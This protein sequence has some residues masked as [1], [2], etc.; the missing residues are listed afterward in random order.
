MSQ[1]RTPAVWFPTVHTGTGT[2]VFTERLAAGLEQHGVRTQIEWL[3]LRAEYA[4][5]TVRVPTPPDWATVAH[6]NTWLRPHFLPRRLPIVATV[7]HCMHTPSLRGRKGIARAAYHRGW[8]APGERRVLRRARC[9]VA[10]SRYVAE[11][12]TQ[13]LCNVDMAVIHN[14]V[15]TRHFCPSHHVRQPGGPFRLLY[16]GGWKTLKGVDLLAPIMR[17]LGPQF[18]LRY[19]GVGMAFRERATMPANTRDLGRL[20]GAAVVAEMQQ[21]DALLFPS[22]SEGFGQVVAEAMACGLPVIAMRGSS[23]PELVD[24]GVTGLLCPRDDV[25]AFVQAARHLAGDVVLRTAMSHAARQDCLRRFDI[26]T[27]V[28]AYLAIYRR[29]G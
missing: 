6:V 21:A 10:V 9:V 7:H 14:G 13:T 20:D 17:M 23:L 26:E 27:M 5:W 3:P 8:I 19:T 24:D 28:G 15:D 29:C 11:T 1:P 16:V 22:R 4:P 2:D 25:G 12:T 18:E